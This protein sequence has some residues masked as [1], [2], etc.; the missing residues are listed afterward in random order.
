MTPLRKVRAVRKV[1]RPRSGAHTAPL[2]AVCA[3]RSSSTARSPTPR[4][5]S[6]PATL[7]GMTGAASLATE[8]RQSPGRMWLTA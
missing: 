4:S 1:A 3:L 5:S 7:A 8:D 2:R 6:T